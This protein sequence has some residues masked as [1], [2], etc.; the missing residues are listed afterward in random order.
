M[1]HTLIVVQSIL[2]FLFCL[3]LVTCMHYLHALNCTGLHLIFS[4]TLFILFYE[5]NLHASL[6]F[7]QQNVLR[8]G[9]KYTIYKIFSLLSFIFD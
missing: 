2:L 3:G 4:L 6:H 5:S 7:K 9:I 8:P 1:C